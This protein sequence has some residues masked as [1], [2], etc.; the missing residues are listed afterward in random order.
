[1]NLKDVNILDKKR[2][3]AFFDA[4]FAIVMTFLV[5]EFKV[6]R[7][8]DSNDE[9]L[10]DAFFEMLPLFICYLLSFFTIMVI[11]LDHHH[12]FKYINKV[13]RPYAVLN[14]VFLLPVTAIPFA[15]GMAGEYLDS[16]FAMT[17]FLLDIFI[18]NIFFSLL[19]FHPIKN[20]QVDAENMPFFNYGATVA[21][22]GLVLGLLSI[23]A[24]Q[25]HPL[26]GCALS[27]LVLVLHTS[28]IYFK[29]K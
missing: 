12:M 6:P 20:G 14:F 4:I 27:F 23:F 17:F 8:E 29:V 25:I 2:F 16:K 7:I 15:T 13:T 26:L 10:K 22:I 1:M 21:K 19:F 3:E 5:L 28:K 18:M 9:M 24:V 11:W